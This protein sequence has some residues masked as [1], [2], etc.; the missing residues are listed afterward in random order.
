MTSQTDLLERPKAGLERPKAGASWEEL[1]VGQLLRGDA[2][3]PWFWSAHAG[4]EIDLIASHDGRR[5]AS[6][7]KRADQPRVTRPI[8]EAVTDLDLR[9]V[10]VVRAGT[11]RLTLTPGIEA[12]PAAEALTSGALAALA[13]G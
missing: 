13:A 10:A 1:V 11:R 3:D 9:G 5:W 6:R 4:A 8:R 7:V 2:G 12:I